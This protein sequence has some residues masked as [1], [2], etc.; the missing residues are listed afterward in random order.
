MNDD[1]IERLMARKVVIDD[2]P[3]HRGG[4]YSHEE[5]DPLCV[6]AVSQ[7]VARRG[8]LEPFAEDEPHNFEL[9]G[10]GEPTATQYSALTAGNLRAARATLIKIKETRG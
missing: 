9:M 2:G 10:D 8:A 5:P 3:D 4:Y 6:E 1:L 7:L